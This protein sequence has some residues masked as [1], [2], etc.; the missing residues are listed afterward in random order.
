[1]PNAVSHPLAD[2]RALRID[3]AL[4]RG[5]KLRLFAACTGDPH[6]FRVGAVAVQT[7]FRP[8]GGALQDRVL[9]LCRQ[10]HFC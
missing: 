8:D 5:E 3:P 4:P 1:M 9:A 10:R 7:V 6:C 2:V